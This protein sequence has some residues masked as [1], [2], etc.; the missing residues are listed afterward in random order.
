TEVSSPRELTFFDRFRSRRSQ[1]TTPHIDSVAMPAQPGVHLGPEH[2]ILLDGPQ[3]TRK[4]LLNG[5]AIAHHE[6]RELS[7]HLRVKEISGVYPIGEDP[8]TGL[9]AALEQVRAEV[10]Q[11]VAEGA[12]ALILTN[13]GARSG[14]SVATPSLLLAATAH[15]H[16]LA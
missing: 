6:A 5:P 13:R 7:R 11:A 14:R 4:V 15:Q 9:Q 1:L 10:D 8:A 16:L 3:H 12:E 2:N